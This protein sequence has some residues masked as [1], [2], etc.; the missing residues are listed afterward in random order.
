MKEDD[1]MTAFIIKLIACLSMLIDHANIVFGGFGWAILP[2]G[3]STAMN[4]IGRLAFPLF[5][6]VL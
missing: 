6:A 4:C 3:L 1:I 5:Q 2:Q